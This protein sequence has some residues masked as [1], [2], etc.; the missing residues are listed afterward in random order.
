MLLN[1]MNRIGS[2]YAEGERWEM[3][4]DANR[5]VELTGKTVGIVGYGASQVVR[6]PGY[7]NH[8]ML[9]FWLTTNTN[10]ILDRGTLRKPTWNRYTAT[11]M[12]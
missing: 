12:S 7:W 5:G 4:Q 1:L 2:S 6:L 10:L 9:R 11:R 8:S 3:D